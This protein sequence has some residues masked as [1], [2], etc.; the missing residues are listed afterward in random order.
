[1]S[2]GE[3]SSQLIEAFNPFGK[4]TCADTPLTTDPQSEQFV[5]LDHDSYHSRRHS[6]QVSRLLECQQ[7]QR[8]KIVFHR[9]AQLSNANAMTIVSVA[10]RLLAK[11]AFLD[12]PAGKKVPHNPG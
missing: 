8:I 6:Q 4:V 9:T 2:T 1:V 12:Q 10:A 7:A 3:E 5:A 11:A